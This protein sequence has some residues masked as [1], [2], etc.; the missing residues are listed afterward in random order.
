MK[1]VQT[2]HFSKSIDPYQHTFGWISPEYHLISWALSFLL[3]ND[4][5]GKVELY[6]SNNAAKLLI[7]D[8][9]LPYYNVHLTHEDLCVPNDKLWALP[10][11]FTYSLQK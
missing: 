1:F 3:L 2:L 8:L 6:A 9:A 5:Y 4:I 11:I 7:D 10:K